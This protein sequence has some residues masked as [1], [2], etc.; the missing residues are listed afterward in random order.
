MPRQKTPDRQEI[1]TERFLLATEKQYR[2]SE[3]HLIDFFVNAWK[4]LEPGTPL[5]LNWHHFLLAEILEATTRQEIQ[6]CVINIEPGS[7]KTIL[8][9]VCW[10]AWTWIQDPRRRFITGG[11]TDRLAV[12]SAMKSRDLIKSDWFQ[13]RWGDRFRILREDDSKSK[14]T[15]DKKGFRVTFGL[16]AR[17]TGWHG[18]HI[19]VDDAHDVEQADSRL[20]RE[21]AVRKVLGTLFSRINDPKKDGWI[22]VGQRVHAHDVSGAILERHPDCVHVN[23]PH[24]F[25]P[26]KKFIMPKLGLQ[27]P[28]EEPGERLWPSVHGEAWYK[29][30]VKNMTEAGAAAQLEQSPEA[31]TGKIIQTSWFK[32][33]WTPETLP[34]EFWGTAQS[35]DTAYEVNT[36]S[37]GWGWV[38][39]GCMPNGKVYI[40]DAAWER[41]HYPDGLRAIVGKFKQHRDDPAVAIEKKSSGQGIIYE[42]LVDD[43][44]APIIIPWFPIVPNSYLTKAER[45]GRESP[46][47]QR[48]DVILPAEAPWIEDFMQAIID[49]PG[50]PMQD[51]V[52][53]FIQLLQYFREGGY[54]DSSTTPGI[55]RYRPD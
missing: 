31:D 7:T 35:W 22:V 15:N 37:S 40:L 38:R 36:T 11:H 32:E 12:D 24:K 46:I 45:A 28:R 43:S 17:V 41:Y 27:D 1:L 42:R 29:D 3:A 50:H 34:A 19:L 30:Q 44:G 25:N 26:V 23:L 39:G 49:L 21:R 20:L 52:D 13:F 9:N 10:P 14:F 16:N 18:N 8:A 2:Q 48:G 33:R 5:Q 54:T 53:A 6:K 4:I 51:L 47:I 55:R